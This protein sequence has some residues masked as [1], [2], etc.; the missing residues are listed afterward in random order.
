MNKIKRTPIE[1]LLQER[2]LVLDGATGTMIQ[3]Y[4]LEEKDYRGEEFAD[5]PMDVKGN[6]DLLSLTQVQICEEVHAAFLAAGADII[7]TNT[8]NATRISQADYGMEDFVAR[9]NETSARTAR[10][11]ADRFTRLEPDK[12]RFVA[13]SMGPTNK[14]ASISPDVNDPSARGVSFDELVLAYQEQASALLRGGVDLL[15]IETVFDVLNAKAAYVG[16]EHAFEQEGITVPIM[17]SVTIADKSGRTLS[18]QTVEAFVV[19]LSHMK[20]LSIGLNCSFGAEG[21]VPFMEDL[22]KHAPGYIS[23]YPNAGLPNQLGE[24]DET[25]ASMAEKIAYFLERRMINIVGG[26]CGTKPEHIQAIAERVEGFTP[27]ERKERTSDTLVSGLEALRIHPDQNFVNV[28]ERTNVAG[29]LRF[30]RLIREKKYEEALS[31]ARKQVEGGAQIIDVNMDDGLLDAKEEMVT[32]LHYLVSEPEIS[33]LP[34]MIDSSKFEVIE[35]GLKC[36]QGKAVVNSISLKDGEKDFIRKAKIIH[37]YGAAVV[38]MAF[39]EEGQAVTAARKNEICARA[40]DIWVNRLGFAPQDIIFDPNILAVATGMEEHNNYAVEF[41]EGIRYIKAHLPH[42]K[43]SGGLSNLSFSFRGNNVVREAMHSVFLYHAIQLG[44]DM[45][46]LNPGMIQVYDDIPQDLLHLVEDVILN[47]HPQ[48][49]EKLIEYAESMK[50]EVGQQETN[51]EVW[52]QASLEERL[53]YALRKGI[54]EHLEADMAE[55]LEKYSPSLKIIEGPLMDGMNRVGELFGEGKMFLPQVVKTA[56]VMKQA[57]AILQPYIEAEKAEAGERSFRAKVQFAT[58][59]GDVHDIGKNI[60]LL[61]LACNNFETSDLGVM[62]SCEEIVQRAIEDEVDVV[63]C[64]GLITPSLDEMIQVAKSMEARGLRIPLFIGGATTSKMHTALKIAPHYSGPVLYAKDASECV[65]IMSK[66]MQ[67]D[68]GDVYLADIRK[69]YA[70]LREAYAQRESRGVSYAEALTKR[71]P[72]DLSKADICKP[73]QLGRFDIKDYDLGEIRKYIDWTFFFAAWDMKGKYPAILQDPE[74]GEEARKLMDDAQ[75][76]LDR[77]EKEKWLR[78]RAVWGIYPANSDGEDIVIFDPENEQEEIARYRG[79]RQ[80]LMTPHSPY[81]YNL[82]DFVAPIA[83]GVKDY[84]AGFTLTTGLGIEKLLQVFEA[85]NDDYSSILL[86]YMADR[87]AEAFGELLHQKI[88]KEWWGFASEEALSIEDLLACKYRGIRPAIGYPACPEHTEKDVLFDLLKPQDIGVHL[89]ENYA[90]S[91]NASISAWVMAHP[92][93]HYF[94]IRNISQE[95]V[96][97]YAQRKA[98][99]SET[100]KRWCGN[101]IRN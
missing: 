13:G 72:F 95:Q 1:E 9:M 41:L 91:P 68:T 53:S 17:M 11:V 76:I 63:A 54:T 98:W 58:V 101:L 32:F 96:D 94:G 35:A 99:D 69:E 64:S 62:V 82:A 90:M 56:R 24:Y 19:S 70:A 47:K 3:Q 8:F 31:I 89:S 52:R 57:V 28:G 26:C 15:L 30:A 71:F 36:L 50:I 34:I 14:T 16:V 85:E 55:A 97:D 65:K 38:I 6:H 42:A 87:L 7:E 33:R 25:P 74:K 79:L 67:V 88:R 100:A 4:K 66:V 40:Y 77:I 92:A 80:E 45:A 43:V 22:C 61:V 18:G 83:A 39:D 5:F 49:G 78:A 23:I 46:I 12:P 51:V 10:R 60:V 75:Q 44:M 2:V 81:C 37:R 29:S 20:L 93:S 21:L 59:K 48:A 73:R 86:K 84:I 27:R